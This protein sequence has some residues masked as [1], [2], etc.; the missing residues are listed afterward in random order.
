MEII[1]LNL[2]PSGVNPVC[3]CSQYDNGRVI[4]CE[5]FNGLTPYTLASGDTVTLNARK[6][7]NTIITASITATQGNNYVDITTTEQLC[8]VVGETLCKLKITNGST[9]I[10]T[11]IFYMQVERD[12]LADGVAS[13]SVIEDLQAQIDAA[14]NFLVPN[15]TNYIKYNVIDFLAGNLTKVS[16]SSAGITFTWTGDT[17]D[18]DGTASSTTVNIVRASQAMP[19]GMTAGETYFLKYA[20]TDTKVILRTIFRDDNNTTLQTIYA[21]G[22]RSITVPN[23]ATKMTMA[24]YITTGTSVSHAKVTEIA[25]LNSKTNQDLDLDIS[26]LTNKSFI[27]R[28]VLATNTDLDTVKNSGCY[29]LDS[30]NTYTNSPITTG[31]AGVLLVFA[32]TANTVTQIAIQSGNVTDMYA[33]NSRLGAF[34]YSWS[35]IGFSRGI[36]ANNTDLNDVNFTCSKVLNS[37]Y[38]YSNC[39]LPNGSAGT[40]LV[41]RSTENTILQMVISVVDAKVFVRTSLAG[42]FSYVWREITGDTYNNTYTTQYYENT[43]NITC[44]PEITADTNNYLASTG[45]DTDRTADIQA[46]LNE[47]GVCHLG[48]GLFV[49]SGVEIPSY[50]T[51]IGSG[52]RTTLRLNENVTEGYAVKLKSQSS[53]QNM[54]I[55]GGTSVP[56]LS[57]T[58]GTRNGVIFEGTRVSGDDTGT[59]YKRAL[60]T[61]CIIYYF[62]GS[63]ILCQKTGTPIDSNMLISDTFV[64]S[65][66]A[67]LNIAYYSEFHRIANSTFQYNYYGVID[68]GGNNNFTNCDFSGN[69]IGILIDNSMD[70]SSNNSHGSFNNCSVNHSISDA[71]VS[72]EGIAIKL[73]KSNL[74]EIFTGMQIFY[75]AIILDKCVGTRFIGANVGRKVPITITD[76]TVV[77]FSDCTFQQPPTDSDALFTQSNNNI[78]KFLNCYLRTGVVYDPMA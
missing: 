27:N 20:T 74:G 62:S 8:A 65:C 29:V 41:F 57:S 32:S 1:K 24:L 54:R 33:R 69:R 3:H 71:G 43:Y 59:T 39:P 19:E 47:T 31:I 9:E 13:Q 51:L 53:I 67:G 11:L 34:T 6:P 21:T 46:M 72:N 25:L 14:I 23:N 77:T 38:T 60:I 73:L 48:A 76:S 64:Y 42:V 63:G 15:L 50:A 28:G 17:C 75:G 70:Q 5:L 61:N 10:G 44:N 36:L 45:D 78:L 4:R 55:S 56:T 7:D 30:G 40:L 2:I 16:S 12:V 37:S 49:V 18:V 66:G 52:N 35:A 22:N 58:I 26:A 68:N